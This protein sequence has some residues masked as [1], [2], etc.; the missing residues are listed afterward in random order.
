MAQMFVPGPYMPMLPRFA[1]HRHGTRMAQVARAKNL[2]GRCRIDTLKDHGGAADGPHGVPWDGRGLDML[3]N[4]INQLD[5][6]LKM[7]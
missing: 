3:E 6:T 7:S 1:F 4:V 5:C 2:H